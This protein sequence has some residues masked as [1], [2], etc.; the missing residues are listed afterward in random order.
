[1]ESIESFIISIFVTIITRT[2]NCIMLRYSLCK[3]FNNLFVFLVCLFYKHD[4]VLRGFAT[5]NWFPLRKKRNNQS[6]ARRQWSVC[7]CVASSWTRSSR[8][9]WNSETDTAAKC[10]YK[11]CLIE[12]LVHTTH[13]VPFPRS[14][15]WCTS[16]P[17]PSRDLGGIVWRPAA[18]GAGQPRSCGTKRDRQ[19]VEKKSRNREKVGRRPLPQPRMQVNT[20]NKCSSYC[21]MFKK[22]FPAV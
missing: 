21:C 11:V 13:L 4:F 2:F 20:P 22:F 10:H 15:N 5:F 14:A 17:L 18:A 12:G 6:M 8:N 16:E 19:R 3:I 7:S 9:G 1:M